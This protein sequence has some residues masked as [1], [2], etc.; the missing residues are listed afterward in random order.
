MGNIIPG[1]QTGQQTG[2]RHTSVHVTHV[3]NSTDLGDVH[4][5]NRLWYVVLSTLQ[6]PIFCLRD[7]L[8]AATRVVRR[9]KTPS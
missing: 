5:W 4:H 8:S 6:R 2:L 3:R 7:F 1:G 9:V